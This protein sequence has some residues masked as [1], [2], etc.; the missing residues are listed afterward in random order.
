MRVLTF[1][2]IVFALCFLYPFMFL[3]ACFIPEKSYDVIGLHSA[4]IDYIV[5]I[6]NE[7]QHTIEHESSCPL[8][9][10]S[11]LKKDLN[12]DSFSEKSSAN[13]IKGLAKLGQCCAVIGKIGFND[14]GLFYLKCLQNLDITPM[15]HKG[16]LP[17]GQAICFITS[18]NQKTRKSSM[19]SP[20]SS[21]EIPLDAKIFH[22][23]RLFHI[24]SSQLQYPNLLKAALEEAKKQ[25]AKISLDLSSVEVVKL[26]KDDLLNIIPKYIDIVFAN[27]SEAFELTNLPPQEACDFLATFCE[28]VAITMGDKG[29]WVKSGKIK[30]YTPSVAAN[31]VDKTGAGDLFASGFLHGYLNHAPLQ[32]CAWLGSYVA[33]KVIQIHGSDIP[34][35]IWKEIYKTLEG[36]PF[37]TFVAKSK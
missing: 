26:Y 4:F 9:K 22:E 28:V 6:N 14:T 12:I 13:V 32:T 23:I 24:E 36:Y 5:K 30:F 25:G 18:S 19:G 10:Q 21:E 27:E 11:I 31:A 2:G 29:C 20:H 33:S 8:T 1:C 37:Q 34:D 16:V 17:T 3:H 35:S 7:N 15:L